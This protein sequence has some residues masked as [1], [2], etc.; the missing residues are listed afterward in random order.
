MVDKKYCVYRHTSPIGKVYIG[1]TSITPERRWENGHGYKYNTHFWNAIVKYG[2]DNFSH[3]I[4]Y[5]GLTREQAF[6]LEKELIYQ[7]ESTNPRY[8]YNVTEGG[9]GGLCGVRISEE[10][11]IKK[12]ESA[13]RSWEKPERRAFVRKGCVSYVPQRRLKASETGKAVWADPIKRQHIIEGMHSGGQKYRR[14]RVAQL[15][16]DG[17]FVKIW[18]SMCAIEK[19]LGIRTGKISECCRGKR[20]SV[21]GYIW[22][23]AED[24][25]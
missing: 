25:A 22:M 2:W 9:C 16:L 7:Y 24:K 21:K 1:V 23:L 17:D 12:S 6:S 14:Q 10:T 19:E 20:S 5:A 15:T 4:L 11:R 18:P 3:E 8:G 13:K